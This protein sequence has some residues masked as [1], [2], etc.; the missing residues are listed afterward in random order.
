M[1]IRLARGEDAAELAARHAEIFPAGPW[2]QSFW[3]N[4]IKDP[5]CLLLI[6]PNESEINGF[7]LLRQVMDEAELLTIGVREAARGQGIGHQLLEKAVERLIAAGVARLFLEVEENNIAARQ[8]YDRL[9]FR[10]VG[11]RQDYYG[12]GRTA[13]VLERKSFLPGDPAHR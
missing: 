8:L 7:C 9:E 1:S 6:S 10:Q 3:E 2:D 13:L 11:E 5:A 12:P 4:C